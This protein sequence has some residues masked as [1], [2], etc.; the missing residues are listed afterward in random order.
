VNHACR[1]PSRPRSTMN[2]AALLAASCSWAPAL[3]HHGAGG[4]ATAWRDRRAVQMLE[5]YDLMPVMDCLKQSDYEAVQACME[6]IEPWL[7][8]NEAGEMSFSLN[9]VNGFIGGTVGVLGTVIATLVKKQQV[10]DRLKC[11]YC[12]GTGQIVCG[13][14]VGSGYLA[15]LGADG[16]WQIGSSCEN[17]EG[18]GSVVCI[19]CQGSG[20]AVPDDF[21]QVLGDSEVGFTDEDYI[22]LFDEVKF[23]TFSPEEPAPAA[24]PDESLATAAKPTASVVL[25][26]AIDPTGGLG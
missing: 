25:E 19:N 24:K 1:T 3:V 11:T 10:K 8:V 13:H 6:Q 5:A 21:L 12:D 17:C 15:T 9:A 7:Q 4:A 26:E 18:T 23:P 14:C 16:T 22:G 2:V 20:V